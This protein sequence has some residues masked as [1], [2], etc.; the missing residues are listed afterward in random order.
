MAPPHPG[1]EQ[2][3]RRGGQQKGTERDLKR[4]RAFLYVERGLSPLT[5]KKYIQVAKHLKEWARDKRLRLSELNTNHC[6]RW[7]NS[8][9]KEGNSTS[10][11]NGKLTAAK[12]FFRFLVFEGDL[13]SNPF[14]QIPY[15]KREESPPRFLSP[16]EAE[17]LMTM[18][19]T[20]T[21]EGLLD[22]VIMELIYASGMRVAEIVNLRVDGV[23]LKKR[24]ILCT[25]KGSKQRFVIFGRSAKEWL[26]RYLIARD[27]L[28]GARK[29]HYVF[30]K[31]DGKRV[32]GTYIWRRIKEHG[33]RAQLQNVSPHVLRHSFATH[34]Y[35]G[36]AS[37]QDVQELLG[38]NE[39]ESTQVYTHVAL[40]HLKKIFN[41]HHPRS[42]LKRGP[43]RSWRDGKG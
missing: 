29:S 33:R 24:C 2:P 5:V 15:Y 27:G 18:P 7:L 31:S 12:I 16:E 35:S 11:I 21:Y 20:T 10:T 25:G 22:R 14:E 43:P 26:E 30:L 17:R 42:S 36:G 1:P 23:N 41:Q 38:H 37:T 9:A 34:L 32:Y 40:E 4:F 13:R 28:R 3:I 6:H 19:D 8:I 39:L